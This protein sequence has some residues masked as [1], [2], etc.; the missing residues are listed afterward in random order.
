MLLN[1]KH[2]FHKL[3]QFSMV[4]NNQTV[5]PTIK[6]LSE[7]RGLT[8]FEKIEDFSFSFLTLPFP[9]F[10]RTFKESLDYYGKFSV[11]LQL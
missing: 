9:T 3:V 5:A 8:N 2:P 6:I 11:F 10:T 4:W 1:D 7:Q